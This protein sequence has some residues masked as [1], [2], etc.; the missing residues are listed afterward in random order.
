MS[1]LLRSFGLAAAVYTV[2]AIAY[3]WPLAIR[4]NGVPHDLGDPILT[5]WFLWWSM[6]AVP[7]TAE[8][9]NAPMFHPAVGVF[10]FSEHL[11]GL[12]PIALPINAITNQPLI[13][14]N[15][16]FI[17]TFVLSGLA[18]HVLAHTLTRR[19]DVSFIAGIA[20]A[21]APY[22]LSQTS[23]IQVL[24][25]FWTP[26]CLAALHRFGDSGKTRWAAIAATCW[27]LQALCCGYYLFF[28]LVLTALWLGWFALGRWPIRQWGVALGAFTAGAVVLVPILLGY[29]RIL[30][31][32]Y[33]FQRAIGEMGAFSADIAAVLKASED[34]LLWGW[35]RVFTRPEGDLFPG[36]IIVLLTILSV[37]A[38]RAD[39][40][41]LSDTHAL[42]LTRRFLVVLLAILVVTSAL[43]LAYGSWQLVIGGVRLVSVSRGDK[44]LTLAFVAAVAAA[45]TLPR[46]RAAFHARTALAFYLGAAFVT[47]ILALGPDPTFMD[48]RAF[49]RM[50]YSWLM[51]MPGFDGLRVPARFWMMTLACLSIVAALAVD[52]VSGVRR[53]TL[54]VVAAI[55]LLLDGW[56]RR[57]PVLAA[58]LLRP[59]PAGVAFRL[60]LPSH[61]SADAEALYQQMFDPIP[62]YNGF[63]GYAPP[64]YEAM[65][66]LF[67]ARDVRILQALS[68]RGE[69]GV[70]VDHAGDRDGAI[71]RFVLAAPGATLAHDASGWSSYRIPQGPAPRIAEASG[72]PVRVVSATSSSDST[73]AAD[74]IDGDLDTRWTVSQ[75]DPSDVTLEL[76]EIAAVS[77]IVMRLGAFGHEFPAHLRIDVSSDGS[78]W[79]TVFDAPPLLESYV[80][81][82]QNPREVP[83]VIPLEPRPAR[84]IRLH[85]T[86]SDPKRTWA[87]SEIQVLR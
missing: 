83:V 9:W 55:G 29:R 19:H 23:H 11:L 46:V 53:K 68:A 80:A 8:W 85:Q 70:V 49:Y 17:A 57:F 74:A 43:P 84:F 61:S 82:V 12:A 63:S 58:P 56:P 40:A 48:R 31:E 35:V 87:I 78:T 16:A 75:R 60:D 1:R 47:W 64:H 38:V 73:R 10:G 69:L 86:A 2:L 45:L 34:L 36:L 5:T 28:L 62:L 76:E 59:T 44:P 25:S 21:F 79:N 65:R 81:A 24:A 52:R 41:P 20:F 51:L 3:T 15:V 26:L 14:H 54:V 77:Q 32:V 6:H 22:R 50:P 66:A 71:R 42:R 37:R 67:D 18:A 30:H 13:G 4:L 72:T 33:G 27:V 7:L 39:A